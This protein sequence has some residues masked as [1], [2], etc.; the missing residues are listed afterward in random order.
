MKFSF[1]DLMRKLPIINKRKLQTFTYYIPAPP[2]RS[3]GYREKQFDRI[4]SSFL[5]N[6]HEVLSISTES[7]S[8]ETSSGMWIVALVKL[9][10]GHN[11]DIDTD[12]TE[13]ISLKSLDTSNNNN[14]NDSEIYYI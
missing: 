3:T 4:L 5:L 9:S 14:V 7:H 1:K 11:I 13:E 2:Y 10:L 8:S 12:Y 6:G